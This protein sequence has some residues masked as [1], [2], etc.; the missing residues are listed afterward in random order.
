MATTNTSAY[1]VDVAREL[2]AD[3]AAHVERISA[4]LDTLGA[5]LHLATV[6]V[7]GQ[8]MLAVSLEDALRMASAEAWACGIDHYTRG[9][10]DGWMAARKQA[11]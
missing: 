6:E 3:A 9:N 1:T 5:P 2:G 4:L 7:A 8:P 11:R 10:F